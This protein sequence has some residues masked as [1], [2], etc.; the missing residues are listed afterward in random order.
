MIAVVECVSSR[1]PQYWMMVVFDLVGGRWI[2]AY[3]STVFL[4][5]R[6]KFVPLSFSGGFTVGIL[7]Q[8]LRSP[9]FPRLVLARFVPLK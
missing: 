8:M 7:N 2:V 3:C 9:L 5:R 6:S 4:F 1:A